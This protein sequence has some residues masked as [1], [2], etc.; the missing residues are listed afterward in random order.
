MKGSDIVVDL[1]TSETFTHIVTF[2]GGV[3]AKW[4]QERAKK[5]KEKEKS[6]SE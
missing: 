4:A 2:L 5:K 1:I 3:F 6:K